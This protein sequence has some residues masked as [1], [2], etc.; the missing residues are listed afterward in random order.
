M[1]QA[2]ALRAAIN[3][4]S[5]NRD[6]SARVIAVSSGKG[7]VG[8]SNITLNLGLQF[9][10][11]GY[12][13]IIFDADFGLA[14]IEI[15]AGV[16]PK[17]TFADVMNGKRGI[18]EVITEGPGG[19]DFISG[20]SGII[21]FLRKED[22]KLNFILENFGLLDKLYDIILIDTSAGV[23]DNVL[24]FIAASRETIVVTTPEPT[25]LTDAYALLK[26]LKYVNKENEL[27]KFHVIV[28]RVEDPKEGHEIFN[29]L[30]SV[31]QNFLKM[32]LEL[33][34]FVPMDYQLIKAVKR[35]RIPVL[36]FPKSS[37]SKAIYSIVDSLISQQVTL[38]GSSGISSFMKRLANI[39]NS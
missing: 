22:Q 1:D 4:K 3:E 21:D 10:K 33:L 8:K 38:K 16:T 39:F 26:A 34:G 5:I 27:P 23:S 13:V 9:V 37:F 11:S 2:N 6:F 35:Q 18:R 30:Q 28:N 25:S 36:Y 12:R 32:E 17:F 14:N 31:S 19:V 29:K 7:G 20:G 15:L 24:N